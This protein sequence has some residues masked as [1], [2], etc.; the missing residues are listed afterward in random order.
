MWQDTQRL[1]DKAG[2]NDSYG[3]RS[4]PKAVQRGPGLGVIDADR[5]TC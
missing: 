5:V 4:Q 1:E 2:M 3:G